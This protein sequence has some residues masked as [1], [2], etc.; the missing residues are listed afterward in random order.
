[1]ND[2]FSPSDI[3]R[4][5]IKQ[6][7]LRR[8]TPTPENYS[9][10]YGEISGGHGGVARQMFM[11]PAD[12]PAEAALRL[13][14]AMRAQRWAE[15]SEILR[16]LG[17]E[18][19]ARRGD[20]SGAA[21]APA[22]ATQP[23]NWAELIRDLQR[24]L[25]MRHATLTPVRKRESLEHVLA[26]FNADPVKLHTRLGGLA[27]SWLQQTPAAAM[28]V[29]PAA[30]PVAMS[31][32][33]AAIQPTTVISERE[34]L[35]A[36]RNLLGST[37]Q[38]AVIDR[39][40]HH[41]SQREEAKLLADAAR[42]A[43][44]PAEVEQLAADLKKFWVRL[45]LAGESRDEVMQAL[46]GLLDMV[47]NNVGELVAD[48]RWLKGQTERLRTILAG[49]LEIKTIREAERGFREVV[50]KQATMKHSLEQAKEALKDML[51][52]FI[53]RLG[54]MASHTDEYQNRIGQHTERIRQAEDI[55]QLG[56]VLEHVM[57]DTRSMQSDM[58]RA[59]DELQGSREKAHNYEQQIVTL[60]QELEA[61]SALV[62]EDPLTRVLNRR[63]FEEAW[64]IEV[65]RCE[66][67]DGRICVAVLDV[68]NFKQLNDTLGHTVGDDALVHLSA[69]IRST[70]RPSDIVARYG[71]EEFVVLL[72]D[73]GLDEA[74][75]IMVRVQ[76]EL[77]RRFFLHD[78]NKVL[79]TFS[80]GITER[81]EG[82]TEQGVVARA[83]KA[84][85]QAKTTGKNKVVPV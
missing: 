63:G 30:E 23:A 10:L 44:T 73:V 6:L 24:G 80:A 29:E 2:R 66:R 62:R 76:R 85:Y 40:G 65:A 1:M 60:Q 38:Y 35:R 50:F 18:A 25:D 67:R 36:L 72:P 33:E 27:K 14:Q 83:D 5:T 54:T 82:E 26:T 47:V 59:R 46:V 28:A 84:L 39:L 22:V 55:G 49:P 71:G 42:A 9:E 7:A 32:R 75:T 74:T 77:T 20:A 53:E 43:A 70:L 37:L 79:I 64:A 12:L 78:N 11:L 19:T 4:E 15:A 51:A 31:A 8:L 3:A 68:D 81:L 52:G 17:P 57:R 56:Q 41:P 61:V 34:S 21:V 48:D 45:E 69:I 58:L 16:G 13:G